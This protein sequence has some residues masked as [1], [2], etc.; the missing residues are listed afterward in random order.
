MSEEKT[1][2]ICEVIEMLKEKLQVGAEGCLL[3][4]SMGACDVAVDVDVNGNVSKKATGI[5]VRVMLNHWE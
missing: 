3:H 4:P 5:T 2:S 1:V